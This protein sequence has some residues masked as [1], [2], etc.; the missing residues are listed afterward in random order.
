MQ[1]RRKSKSRTILMIF[2]IIA[3]IVGVGIGVTQI[4]D[5]N[6]NPSEDDNITYVDVTKNV[7]YYENESA[8]GNASGYHDT[9]GYYDEYGYYHP[10]YGEDDNYSD[11][12]LKVY[13][14][15][16]LNKNIK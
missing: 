9:S 6:L 10:Y 8:Y 16:D 3:F 14:P 5:I 7:S 11:S 1:P 15:K 12:N 4:F 2:L 13:Q